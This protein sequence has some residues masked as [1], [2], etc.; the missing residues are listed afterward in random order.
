MMDEISLRTLHISLEVWGTVFCLIILLCMALSKNFLPTRRKL[1]IGLYLSTALLLLMDTIAWIYRG[2][3]GLIAYWMVR[4]SNFS[5]F[6]L[7][8]VLVL[9]Y[10]VLLSSYLSREEKKRIRIRNGLVFGCMGIA[11]LLVCISA[12]TGL[13]YTF[14]A[15]NLYHRSRYHF[16]SS[17]FPVCAMAIDLSILLQYRRALKK[18]VFFAMLS[19]LL[20]PMVGSVLLVFFYGISIT[21]ISICVSAVVMFV[22][23]IMEQNQSMEQK[24]REAYDLRTRMMLSQI[25]PHFI[26]NT[27]STIKYLCRK[28]P[29]QATE[30][31]DIFAAYLRGNLDSL[32]AVKP[33][34]FRKELEHTQNYLALEKRRFGER[35]RVSCEILEDDFLVP[36]LILQPLVENAVK[37]G[38]TKKEEGGTI[39][40]RSEKVE[41]AYYITVEDDG[42]GFSKETRDDGKLHVGLE[43]TRSR[44]RNICG[45]DMFITSTPGRGTKAVIRIPN[46]GK[47]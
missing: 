34:P 5:V 17:V 26:Y 36:S 9:L 42:V 22:V 25:R 27:L 11:I 19:Y 44:L 12:F 43:N 29:D 24:E 31:I 10:H 40:I 3:G 41:K 39:R 21:N 38:I 16:L 20:F 33:I 30:T 46:G 15:G 32:M 47:G 45:G 37:H 35:I 28:E 1:M 4:I 7:S 2:D 8:D 13:Y 23:G 6:F 18:E 14:D